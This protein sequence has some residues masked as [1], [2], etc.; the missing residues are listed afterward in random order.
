MRPFHI[1]WSDLRKLPRPAWVLYGGTFINRFG[2]FVLT[3]LVLYLTERGYSPRAAGAALALYGVGSIAANVVGGHLADVLGRRNTIALSM[4]SS[5][6]TMLALSQADALGWILALTA[7]AGF[8]AELYRPAS[9]A[10]IADLTP[11]GERVTAYAVYRLAVNAG[12]AAGP[13]VAGFVAERS[14]LL[15]FVGDA[16]TSAVY[17][18]IAVF[19]LPPDRERVQE[20]RR[21]AS[22]VAAGGQSPHWMRTILRDRAFVG[23]LLPSAM[24]ALVIHQGYATLPLHV[25]AEGYSS[26]VYGLLMSVNGILIITLELWLT[27]L[28]R[29][30]PARVAIALGMLLSGIGFGATGWAHAVPALVASVVIWTFGEMCL[31]PV[32]AA[33]VADLAP[34]E[35]RGRYQGAF[36]MTFSMG[37]VLAPIVG[38][39]LLGI[40]PKLLWG[41][42]LAVGALAALMVSKG[43]VR[44]PTAETRA[45][46]A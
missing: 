26:S 7:V 15:L 11:A 19:F 5:A 32:A 37:L 42:C 12:V 17:G 4:F 29:R 46:P 28:T 24:I 14:F 13:A 30:I 25:H 6:A 38:T 1:V 9:A 22:A 23:F 39:T 33:Y 18:L 41:A 31:S 43:Q 27:G 2:G 21:N 44:A 34:E 36:A 20:R 45:S 10:L 16:I 8:C 35:L 40:E 3:F